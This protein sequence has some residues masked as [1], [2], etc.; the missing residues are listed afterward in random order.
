MDFQYDTSIWSVSEL[1]TNIISS[2]SPNLESPFPYS[3]D[4]TASFSTAN[5]GQY[6]SSN[7]IPPSCPPAAVRCGTCYRVDNI[8]PYGSSSNDQIYGT[9]IVEIVD[10]CPAGN[11]QNY[12]KT[13]VAADERCGSNQTNSLDVDVDAYRNLTLRMNGGVEWDAVSSNVGCFREG[14]ADG[15]GLES[16]KSEDQHHAGRAV[17]WLR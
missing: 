11:A 7:Y 13:K 16:T 3:S 2:R 10:A 8:G 4:Q 12:C 15:I 6:P 5:G 1:I 14:F 9:V 17:P